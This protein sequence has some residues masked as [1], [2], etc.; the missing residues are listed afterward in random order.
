[1]GGVAGLEHLPSGSGTILRTG[2]LGGRRRRMA[3]RGRIYDRASPNADEATL[4]GSF[5]DVAASE[6][7]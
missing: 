4:R 1:M 5:S 7:N 3:M 6:A 2:E